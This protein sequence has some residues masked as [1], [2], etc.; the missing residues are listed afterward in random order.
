M[1]NSELDLKFDPNNQNKLNALINDANQSFKD[2][3]VYRSNRLKTISNYVGNNYSEN[4]S[5]S[6][7]PVNLLELSTGIYMRKLASKLPQVLVSTNYR[8]E[9]DLRPQALSLQLATNQLLKDK[10]LDFLGEIKKC[11]LDALFSIGICKMSL[12][13]HSAI[14]IEGQQFDYGYPYISSV[15]LDDF[16]IDLNAKSL[17]E[18]AYIGNK[19]KVSLE[20]ILDNPN[21]FNGKA[22]EYIKKTHSD[23]GNEDDR[24]SN[25]GGKNKDKT[26]KG[27]KKYIE[28]AEL[29]L[30]YENL[31][32]ILPC[33]DGEICTN[34]GYLRA[35]YFDGPASNPLGM[36]YILGY[37]SVPDNIMPLAPASLL[38]DMHVLANNLF[39]KLARQAERQKTNLLVDQT[40]T[41]DG[42]RIVDASDG[43][44]IVTRNPD[45]C[46]EARYGGID[47]AN[48]GFFT[49][50]RDL[51]SYFAGNLDTLGGLSPQA[52][53]LG[54]DKL[55]AESAS[56]RIQAMR[57]TTLEF[58]TNICRDL[59]W[60]L[61]T[62]PLIEL[63]LYKRIKGSNIEIPVSF[64][65]EDRQGDF[66]NYNFSIVPF[67]MQEET[68]AT[69]MSKFTNIWQT[70]I[71]P[72]LPIIQQTGGQ[73]N[74]EEI[75]ALLS[76]Y[77]DFPEIEN[78]IMMVDQSIQ[79][80]NRQNMPPVGNPPTKSPH[81][82][83]TY[84]RV[85]RQGA[86]SNSKNGALMTALFGGGMNDGQKNKL[87]N[88]IG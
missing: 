83:R 43:E 4:G 79:N 7:I 41:D 50:V 71:L 81:T 6:K 38:I 29:Y 84:E 78:I 56:E 86:T 77:Y 87:V 54:Q 46:K 80:Y 33:N 63:P 2:G 31:Y 19:S 21:F 10:K 12:K 57:E 9:P 75:L 60:Y 61:W 88:P 44:A 58:T 59:A 62:D 66:L 52:D 73:L 8:N 47:N 39:R 16:I 26:E 14:D 42:T 18:V 13:K 65:P 36:Y 24:V 82:T 22:I 40:S 64:N 67:S 49:N 11:V 30:P 17:K 72:M 48:F 28:I 5:K 55:L 1:D 69:K 27:F 53:T 34:K 68:P 45:K 37:N 3:K 23:G 70:Y 25:I 32:I 51:Y 85:N 76:Q 74:T 15:S 20:Y 35:T